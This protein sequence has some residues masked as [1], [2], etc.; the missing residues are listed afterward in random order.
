[1]GNPICILSQNGRLPPFR[2]WAARFPF[3][4]HR[5][6]TAPSIHRTV[7]LAQVERNHE[8]LHHHLAPPLVQPEGCGRH[9]IADLS[10]IGSPRHRTSRARAWGAVCDSQG[11]VVP[12]YTALFI[13][14]FWLGLGLDS[15]APGLDRARS[16]R[17]KPLSRFPSRL[18]RWIRT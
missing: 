18:D 4:H 10:R 1:M 12:T 7:L 5:S 15:D 16:L 6:T 9:V 17:R 11:R 14:T 2:I 13:P 8:G 3:R